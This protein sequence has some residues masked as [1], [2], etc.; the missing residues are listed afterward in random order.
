MAR[1]GPRGGLSI[2]RPLLVP[3]VLTLAVALL[4]VTGELKGWSPRWFN[5]DP[6]GGPQLSRVPEP[7]PARN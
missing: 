5:P 2:E 6:G 3:G 1:T 7:A 4:R